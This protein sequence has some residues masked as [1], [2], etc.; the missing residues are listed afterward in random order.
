MD[1]ERIMD[2]FYLAYIRI[3]KWAWTADGQFILTL[4]AAFIPPTL[5]ILA[6][7]IIGK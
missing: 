3:I 1:L 4:V 7:L 2:W 5:Y 6:L